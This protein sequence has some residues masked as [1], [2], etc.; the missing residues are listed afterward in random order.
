MLRWKEKAKKRR[1]SSFERLKAE[2]EERNYIRLGEWVAVGNVHRWCM[3]SK[4]VSLPR[5]PEKLLELPILL[6]FRYNF[7][8]I[9]LTLL[10]NEPT[11]RKGTSDVKKHFLE[12]KTFFDKDLLSVCT[13]IWGW[14]IETVSIYSSCSLGGAEWPMNPRKFALFAWNVFRRRLRC[15]VIKLIAVNTR[16][17]FHQL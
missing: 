7:Q 16:N 13:G 2:R 17:I 8:W 4:K 14:K 9:S 10:I 6:D 15:T 1:K 3:Q 12:L 5:N 11:R